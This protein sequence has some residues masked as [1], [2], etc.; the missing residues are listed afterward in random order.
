MKKDEPFIPPDWVIPKSLRTRKK[1][2][3]YITTE[4]NRH[5]DSYSGKDYDTLQE[6]AE[7]LDKSIR[8]RTETIDK[9]LD[10]DIYLTHLD[11]DYSTLLNDHHRDTRFDEIFGV[12]EDSAFKF[13]DAT[14]ER[15]APTADGQRDYYIHWPEYVLDLKN[16]E[17]DGFYRLE[18]PHGETT[19]GE[20]LDRIAAEKGILEKLNRETRDECDDLKLQLTILRNVLW[21]IQKHNLIPKWEDL[22]DGR[23]PSTSEIKVALPYTDQ[24]FVPRERDIDPEIERQAIKVRPKLKKLYKTAPRKTQNHVRKVLRAMNNVFRREGW[25]PGTAFTSDKEVFQKILF[26]IDERAIPSGPDRRATHMAYQFKKSLKK[27]D[28]IIQEYESGWAAL[29]EANWQIRQA[30]KE[31][32]EVIG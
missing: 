5:H 22:F 2:S 32:D 20:Q 24:F 19:V 28:I 13:G 11:G 12:L 17:W 30:R 21:Q 1:I 7:D 4:W 15:G 3:D 31:I 26:Q 8:S 27:Y 29:E 14:V 23:Q 10:H 6:I 25:R 16:P 18:N 9:I